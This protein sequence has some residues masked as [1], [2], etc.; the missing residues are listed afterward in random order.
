MI[1]LSGLMRSK[2]IGRQLGFL[3]LSKELSF[4]ITSFMSL[5]IFIFIM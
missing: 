2:D 1:P 4:D 3:I 5:S